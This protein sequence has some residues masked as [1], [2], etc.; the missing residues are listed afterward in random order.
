MRITIPLGAALAALILVGACDDAPTR[1]TDTPHA[2]GAAAGPAAQSTAEHARNE[3]LA[4]RLALALGRADVRASLYRTLQA[5]PHPERKV[6]FQWL[7]DAESGRLRR[8]LAHAAKEPEEVV[9]ADAAAAMSLEVY[10]PVPGHRQRWS[11][12]ADLLVATAIADGET[13]VAFDLQGRRR[14]LDPDTPP[15]TP[16]LAVVPAEH[17]YGGRAYPLIEP[18]PEDGGGGTGSYPSVAPGLYMTYASFTGTFEGWLKGNPEFEVHVLG[19]DGTG[20][21]LK[22]LQCAGEHAGGPYTFDM[23]SKTWSGNVLLFSQTQ[24]DAFKAQH[25]GQS[26]RILVLEDD[27]TACVIKQ[28]K[29]RLTN[30]FKLLDTHYKD[31]T[32]GR[33]SVYIFGR[34]WHRATILQKI[35]NAL[36]SVIKTNDEI[37]GNAIQDAV[38][39][40]TWPGASWIVKGENNVT[41]GGIALRLY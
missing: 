29:D 38:V 36:A 7:L 30:L 4:R 21:A 3:R 10:L 8:D 19:Q 13:P 1:S 2:E 28:D 41:N 12:G 15:L 32:G 14:L 11:G 16:V 5:S 17:Q 35:F 37:V 31:L 24:I 27:D 22:S 20:T 6:H 9:A 23:N 25:P 39:G 34:I 18:D 33:D 40:Q 26:L